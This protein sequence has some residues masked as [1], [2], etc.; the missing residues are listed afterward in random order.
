MRWLSDMNTPQLRPNRGHRCSHQHLW[1]SSHFRT[2]SG[3][4]LWRQ[5][6]LLLSP[7]QTLKKSRWD[8]YVPMTQ[9]NIKMGKFHCLTLWHN[10]ERVSR[11]E[12]V[13]A[14]VD[15]DEQK[16]YRVDA[17]CVEEAEACVT[18]VSLKSKLNESIREVF[19]TLQIENST[20]K[21]SKEKKHIEFVLNS[22]VW[23]ACGF[24]AC[25]VD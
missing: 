25:V 19:A 16:P 2:K 17:D 1:V 18:L 20:L 13:A 9:E 4:R 10:C 11:V 7:S 24:I 3:H 23:Q 15:T 21:H 6:H 5:H 8:L 12:D 14:R 22:Y